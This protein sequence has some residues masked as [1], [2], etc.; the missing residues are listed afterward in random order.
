MKD[1]AEGEIGNS[2]TNTWKLFVTVMSSLVQRLIFVTAVGVTD[3][4][5]IFMNNDIGG[6]VFAD[7]A[8]DETLKE[9]FRA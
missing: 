4:S 6:A 8:F 9:I 7:G 5:V 1:F 3:T 2:E